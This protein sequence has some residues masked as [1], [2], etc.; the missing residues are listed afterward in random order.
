MNPTFFARLG[1]AI[2]LVCLGLFA[3]LGSLVC[4][5]SKKETEPTPPAVTASSATASSAAA[6]DAAAL[7]SPT[8]PLGPGET[9]SGQLA[10]EAQH[11]PAIKPNA[12]DV[13]AAFE[14]AGAPVPRKQQSLGKTYQSPFCEGGYTKDAKLAINV[15]EYLDASA[16]AA[17]LAV[18]KT[19]FPGI[20]NRKLWTH[21]ATTVAIIEQ[22]QGDSE[23]PATEKKLA[24][25]Y[26]GL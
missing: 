1:N 17:G 16:A 6:A 3:L 20:T 25:V 7:A 22:V 18:A 10:A 23:V 8:A 14:R 21:K 26:M 9:L 15:C 24:D 4:S 13:F 11:R 5:C 19:T 12:D 2:K